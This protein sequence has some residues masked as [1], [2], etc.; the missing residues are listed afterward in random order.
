[1]AKRREVVRTPD[2]LDLGKFMKAPVSPAVRANG[3]IFTGGYVPLDPETGKAVLGSIEDQTR[4]TLQNLK[5]VL[6]LAGSS[7]EKV[8]K[9]AIFISEEK[10]FEGLNKVYREFFNKDFPARRTIIS[11]LVG[12][13]RVEIDC[14]ALE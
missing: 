8:V 2:L 14:I 13:F 6:E 12:G 1:M 7:L 5:M 4:R 9:V 11:P 10:D 3:F